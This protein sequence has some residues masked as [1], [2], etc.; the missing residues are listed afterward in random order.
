MIRLPAPRCILFDLDGT[1]VDSMADI[2]ASANH[3]RQAHGM[4]PLPE[5]ELAR[6][7]GDGA[8]RLMQR[9][10]AGQFDAPT[11]LEGFDLREVLAEFRAHYIDH[12]LIRTQPYPGVVDALGALLPRPMALASNKPEPMCVKIV[13]G[14]GL[15]PALPLVVGARPSV[16][17]KPD[18]AILLAAL[19]EL[20]LEDPGPDVWMVGDS[21]NDVKAARAIGASAIA[22][23][24]G[25]SNREQLEASG[26]DLMLEEFPA[27]LELL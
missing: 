25:L 3:V 2:A 7:V 6:Y 11:E 21:Q 13:E 23:A 4:E 5:E 8:P 26:P 17:V 1:L 19:A 15:A 20:G 22:V 9:A 12:C 18:P 24:W 14:L 16:P 27:I 10:M